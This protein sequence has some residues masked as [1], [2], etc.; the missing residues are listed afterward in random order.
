MIWL[1]HHSSFK[2]SFFGIKPGR[3]NALVVESADDFAIGQAGNFQLKVLFET[4]ESEA[5]G[6]TTVL[7][8]RLHPGQ[9]KFFGLLGTRFL[10]TG[11]PAEKFS[12]WKSSRNF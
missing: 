8:T 6:E 3:P 12:Y 4:K 7:Q 9:Q 11:N 5:L 2:T 10:A 1:Y